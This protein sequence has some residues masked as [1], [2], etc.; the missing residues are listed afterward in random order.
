MH[1][2]ATWWNCLNERSERMAIAADDGEK[3]LKANVLVH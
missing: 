3:E 1:T 2:K